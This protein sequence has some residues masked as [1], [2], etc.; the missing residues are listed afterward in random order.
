LVLLLKRLLVIV[1]IILGGNYRIKAREDEV[2]SGINGFNWADRE[3][4]SRMNECIRHRGPDGEGVFIND[5]ISLGHVKITAIDSIEKGKQP[6]HNKDES[7]W[8]IFDGKIYNSLLLKKKI[9]EKG[10]SLNSKNDTELILYAYEKNGTE[11]FEYFNGEFAFCLYDSKNKCIYLVRDR[12]GIKPL[13][14][15]Y[16]G[17]KFIF[18]S[19]IKTFHILLE[20]SFDLDE[21]AVLEYFLTRNISSESFFKNIKTVEPGCYIK[22]DL[23]NNKV[24]K[25]TYFDVL[26]VV[27]KNQFMRNYDNTEK[28][29]IEELDILLNN[30][31]KDQFVSEIPVGTICS[32]GVDSSLLTA[33]AKKYTNDLKIFNVKVDDAFLDESKYAKKVAKHLGLQII[34]EVLDKEKFIELYKNCIYLADLPFVHPNSIG[35]HLINKRAKR[36]GINVILA[37]EGADELF[38]GY[39]HYKYFYRRLLLTKTPILNFFNNK[40]RGFFYF[41]DFTGYMLEDANY[42]LKHYK[43]L[44]INDVR[45]SAYQIFYEML[46]FLKDNFER[47][48]TAYILKDM[49]YYLPP[50]LRE[51]E[52]MAMGAGV[53]IRMPY[54]DNRIVDFASNLPLKFKVNFFKTKYLLK[55]VAERYLPKD[56][57]YRKKMGFG[58]PTEKWLGDKSL[59]FKK[60]MY[61]DWEKI[62]CSC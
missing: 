24:S 49:K 2:M 13:Y 10:F 3:L 22:F 25:C 4:L 7:I 41:N 45:R 36:E 57:V 61:T 60:V 23:I 53:E 54:L 40:L 28:R 58:I 33:I 52:R 18:S 17:N 48:M 55:K 46:E 11:A 34:E 26:H 42:L 47:E 37:G 15:Y 5:H 27:S 32:G 39:E 38:G 62:F 16:T 1:D 44:P 14:Y 56:I 30:V 12:L 29:L 21:N 43:D 19:E 31:V 20:C 6:M 50:T 51:A 35:I 8:I 59:D 9:E